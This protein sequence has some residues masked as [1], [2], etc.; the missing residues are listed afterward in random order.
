MGCRALS[1]GATVI[2]AL[3]LLLAGCSP[4][5]YQGPVSDHF[6]GREFHNDTP[7]PHGFSDLLS[8][9]FSQEDIEW[10][11]DSEIAPGS[12][13]LDRVGAGALRLTWVNHSTFLIQADGLNL[14]T[15]PIWS[16]RASPVSFAGPKRHHP[17]AVPFA[18]LPPIDVVMISHSHFDHMDF[19]TLKRLHA[20]H[21]PLFVVPL[22]NAVLLQDLGI[23]RIVE[24]D[25][26]QGIALANGCVLSAVKVQHWSNRRIL[27][28]DRNLSLWAGFV[29]ETRGGPV[30]FGGD[31]G[32]GS[33]YRETYA[34]YGAMRAALLPI[35]AY[36]PRW[37]MA[38]QHMGPDEAVVAHAEIAS[39]F[40]LGIHWGAFKL[41][42]EGRFQAAEHLKGL[43]ARGQIPSGPFIAPTLGTAYDVPPLLPEK[44]QSHV[45][46][47]Y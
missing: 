28:S 3:G 15:D 17:P 14:L 44:L 2:V 40:S 1:V 24:L 16:E 4:P 21:D 30:Y 12:P 43:A 20:E 25:W 13:V 18:S 29:M 23:E 33:H 7:F 37:F 5:R 47:C 9:M 45:P 35:G 42:P 10:P 6:D 8:Y 46:S 39:Q 27:P 38:Y 32:Y 22:G 36:L 31:S 34:R 19:P 41:A 11:Q 26:W